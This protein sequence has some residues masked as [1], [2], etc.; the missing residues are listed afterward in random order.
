MVVGTK[1]EGA[2][3]ASVRMVG[4]SQKFTVEAGT[5]GEGVPL[6]SVRSVGVGSARHC[7]S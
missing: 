1:A 2:A 6:G 5:T 7:G 4:E 3:L